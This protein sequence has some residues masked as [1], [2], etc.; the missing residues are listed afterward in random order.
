MEESVEDCYTELIGGKTGT[1]HHKLVLHSFAVYAVSE[2]YERYGQFK[3]GAVWAKI[4]VPNIPVQNGAVHIIDNV[5]GIVTNTIDQVRHKLL[6]GEYND[7]HANQVTYK[8]L[9]ESYNF[10]LYAGKHVEEAS[11]FSFRC[12]LCDPHLVNL[13]TYFAS[14]WRLSCG[15]DRMNEVLPLIKRITRIWKRLLSIRLRLRLRPDVLV[16]VSADTNRVENG[17]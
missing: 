16:V 14:R 13:L 10:P 5:L 3:R 7:L 4:L 1:G 11:R 8:D 9:S 6:K 12:C 15:S 17:I 2:I